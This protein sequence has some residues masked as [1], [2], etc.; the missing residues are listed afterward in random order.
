MKKADKK[1]KAKKE[2]SQEKNVAEETPED[3]DEQVATKLESKVNSSKKFLFPTIYK[4]MTA[5]S[6]T[7]CRR[8]LQRRAR[9]EAPNGNGVSGHEDDDESGCDF[10]KMFGSINDVNEVLD[11][12]RESLFIFFI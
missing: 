1:K 11:M 3:T 2:I 10:V 5:N 6:L 7:A 8:L 4:Q 12:E 9:R